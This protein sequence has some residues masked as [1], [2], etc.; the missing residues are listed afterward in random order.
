MAGVRVPLYAEYPQPGE[1]H[2]IV[3]L[4]AVQWL[5]VGLLF[6]VLWNDWRG[7]VWVIATAAV[8]CLFAGALSATGTAT[9][10]VIISYFALFVLTV[11]VWG[12]LARSARSKMIL[13]AVLSV[14]NL[15][16]LLLAYLRE[17]LG[18]GLGGGGKWKYGVLW[19]VLSDPHNPADFCWILLTFVLT[20]GCL[21]RVIQWRA[22]VRRSGEPR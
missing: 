20:V 2:A 15:G 18:G 6:P 10:V 11:F 5:G 3:I 19:P 14:V 16:G 1:F 7:V 12:E 22:Q 21:L 8:M 13:A 9:V 4:T 17:D